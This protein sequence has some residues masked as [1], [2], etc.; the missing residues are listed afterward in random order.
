MDKWL[1]KYFF[2][3]SGDSK[4]GS[5]FFLQNLKLAFSNLSVEATQN[6]LINNQSEQVYTNGN[7]R[8]VCQ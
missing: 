2:Y 5:V 3:R 8:F 4:N 1:L 7:V 6:T